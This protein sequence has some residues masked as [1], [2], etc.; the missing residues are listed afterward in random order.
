MYLN[1]LMWPQE[2]IKSDRL[3]G[4]GLS[5][6]IFVCCCFSEVLRDSPYTSGLVKSFFFDDPMMKC[7]FYLL[8]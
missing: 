5:I 1:L 6:Y 2:N 7:I 4:V 3:A 8:T